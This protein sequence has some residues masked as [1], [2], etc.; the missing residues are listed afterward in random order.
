MSVIPRLLGVVVSSSAL[1]LSTVAFAQSYEFS[2][3]QDDSSIEQT[4]NVS[5]P[6]TGTLIGNYDAETTPDGTSTLPGIFGGSGN[7]PIDF[8]A[9][10]ALSG[11]NSVSPQGS[12]GFAL[13]AS[14]ISA[15]IDGFQMD[16][17]G[18]EVATVAATLNL[19]YS[20]FR[21]VS[22]SALFIGGIEIP[23]P[24]G[25]IELQN[26][27]LEQT[28]PSPIAVLDGPAGASLLGVLALNSTF[29]FMFSGQE[30]VTDPIPFLLPLDG[31]LL[32]NTKGAD[33]AFFSEFE[34]DQV[35]PAVEAGIDSVPLPV[36]TILPP[37]GTANLLM[38]ASSTEGTNVGTW[39]SS[40]VAVGVPSKC[41]GNPDIDGNG[42]VDG[43][44]LTII[45]AN[46][47]AQPGG[48]DNNPDVTCDG[49][50]NGAD[51]ASVLSAWT[52]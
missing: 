29:S 44:D 50:V 5:I 38:S 43:A 31:S 10:L 23:I 18:G 32:E 47:G 46:W 4:L 13:D 25:D 37:G 24:L 22:P 41:S 28:T 15:T 34:F 26:W 39:R 21:T 17:L 16:V 6:L 35:V 19:I 20:T 33:I 27:T 51:L 52:G 36:P 2:I 48:A 12:F 8:S 3:D 45:L 1:F 11:S 9:T 7:N 30:I 49:V 42:F 40:L 14:G